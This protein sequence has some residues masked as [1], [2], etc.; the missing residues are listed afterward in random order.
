M[1]LILGLLDFVLGF[2]ALTLI[3]TIG[4]CSIAVWHYIH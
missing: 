1:R 2:F 4:S 3:F